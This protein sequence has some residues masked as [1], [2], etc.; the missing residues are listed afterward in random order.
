MD[1]EAVTRAGILDAASRIVSD[2]G[3]KALTVR[4]VAREVGASTMVVYTHFGDKDG[5]LEA[6]MAEGFGR[7][8]AALRRVRG[9]EPFEH[10]RALGRAYRAFALENPSYYRL[11]WSHGR[12]PDAAERFDE[13]RRHGQEAFGVLLEAVTRVMTALD[14]PA[15]D[16]EPA[17]IHVWATVHGHVSLELAGEIPPEAAG[18][19]YERTLDYVRWGLGEGK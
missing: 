14:R 11:L 1:A 6:L 7:F 3:L 4:R 13:A 19:L 8:A 16:V 2:E 10:L 9:A 18:D 5:L 17:A 15:R 12:P